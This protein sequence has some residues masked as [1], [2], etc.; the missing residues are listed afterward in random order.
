ME[1]VAASTSSTDDGGRGGR[2]DVAVRR[3]RAGRPVCRGGVGRDG[4]G[5]GLR[6]WSPSPR[7]RRSHAPEIGR[8]SDRGDGGLVAGAA[9]AAHERAD[10]RCDDR[11]DRDDR[12]RGAARD[13]AAAARTPGRSARRSCAMSAKR[14]PR[15]RRCAV[16]AEVEGWRGAGHRGLR[17]HVLSLTT[18][19]RRVRMPGETVADDAV[20]RRRAVGGGLVGVPLGGAQPE[21]R[22]VELAEACDFAQDR[23]REPLQSITC[24]S[25]STVA[26][27]S[28]SAAAV[29]C[30]RSRRADA[31]GWPTGSGR[32]S[33]A[34]ASERVAGEVEVGELPP[35]DEEC[36]LGDLLGVR[37]VADQPVRQP[38]HRAHVRAVQRAEGVLAPARGRAPRA[39]RR[40]WRRVAGRRRACPILRIVSHRDSVRTARIVSADAGPGIPTLYPVAS[41]REYPD[42]AHPSSRVPTERPRVRAAGRQVAGKTF[43][44]DRPLVRPFRKALHG[45]RTPLWF[46]IGSLGI[47]TL[48]PPRRICCSS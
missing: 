12:R 31:R 9:G 26:G 17:V 41:E 34:T 27:R 44:H 16:C 28:S 14:R 42:T 45:P 36:L 29:V 21:D 15:S 20:R 39:R 19:R 33:P 47:L 46:E 7:S 2:D 38:V 18:V 30:G 3:D 35:G 25:T 10:G 11:G 22:P 8:G 23:V 37:G 24:C 32:S 4:Q 5:C 48:D 1:R 43:G 6:S 40:R 13:Q